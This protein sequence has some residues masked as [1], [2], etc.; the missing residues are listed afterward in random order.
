MTLSTIELQ[1]LESPLPPQV[2]QWISACR[3]R[4]ELYWD[5]FKEKPLPQYIE[6]DFDLV[7]NAIHECVLRDLI[8]GLLFVEWGCGFG[9]VTGIAGLL[10]LDAIGI[11]AEEFLC[12]QAR[13]LFDKHAV[14]AEVWQGNFL[15]RGSRE[16]AEE[17]DPLV[18]L[19]HTIE[20]AY[21]QHDM[22]LDDFA[23]VFAYPWPGEEHFLRL[24]FDRFARPGA[25][26]LM[27]RGPYHIELFQKR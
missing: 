25:L 13:Q 1:L 8:D 3:A 2:E 4:I 20:P 24:V 12:L 9:V 18:S 6:C 27:F 15:P 10:G 21:D 19:T 17:E 22:P 11:E 7:A 5:R 26:L 23:I 14:P 16:L